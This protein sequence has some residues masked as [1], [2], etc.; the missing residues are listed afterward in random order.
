[1]RDARRWRVLAAAVALAGTLTGAGPVAAQRLTPPRFGAVAP[2]SAPPARRDTLGSEVDVVGMGLGAALGGVLGT[3]AG[4]LVGFYVSGGNRI[5]GDDTCGFYGG[6]LGALIGE[7]IG[8]GVGAHV[9]NLRRGNPFLDVLGAAATGYLFGFIAAESEA[10]TWLA[11]AGLVQ[12]GATV[13]IERATA[14]ARSR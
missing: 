5:C 11:V 13:G 7:P 6:I 3:A 1:M 8:A 2:A 10:P 12:I 4:G 9:V 14:D